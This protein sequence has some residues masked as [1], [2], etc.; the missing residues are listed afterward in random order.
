[1]IRNSAN[2]NIQPTRASRERT[3]GSS[4]M[5]A[6]AFSSHRLTQRL[7]ATPTIR[8]RVATSSFGPNRMARSRTVFLT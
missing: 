3:G 5:R 6:S 1:M 7:T 8:I 2:E 4:S